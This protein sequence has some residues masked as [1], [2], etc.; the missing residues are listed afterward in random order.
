VILS[1]VYGKRSPRFDTYETKTFW[2]VLHQWEDLLAPG[3]HPPV[4]LLPF[5][6]Y[7]PERWAPWKT[8]C[9]EVGRSQRDLYYGLLK[10]CEGRIRDGRENGSY[11]EVVLKRQKEFGLNKEQ[12]G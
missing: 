12:I 1:I 11:M 3:A 6:K 8:L 10:E 4:D 7:V 9:K 2:R 5:L